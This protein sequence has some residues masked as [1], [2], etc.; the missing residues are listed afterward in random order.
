V[1]VHMHLLETWYEREFGWSGGATGSVDAL[2]NIGLL[3]L[4]LFVAHGVWLDER[5][6]T[7]L[8]DAGTSVVTNPGSNLRLHAGVAPVRALLAAGVNVALG[9]DNMSLGDSE[10]ILDELRL[11][12]ALQRRPGVDES[13]RSATLLALVSKNGALHC[14]RPHPQTFLAPQPLPRL[15]FTTQPSRR[16]SLCANR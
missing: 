5:E 15:R 7:A 10:V 2:A 6:C 1:P 13:G 11:A 9:T 14:V 3:T 12:R 4:R 16:S 8:V